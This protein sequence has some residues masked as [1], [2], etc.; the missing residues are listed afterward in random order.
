MGGK[1]TAFIQILNV[2]PVALDGFDPLFALLCEC[3]G[4][5]GS[6][7]RPTDI[8]S[9][10][11]VSENQRRFDVMSHTRAL[12]GVESDQNHFEPRARLNC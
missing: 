4:F 12:R 7:L 11:R 10:E 9:E 8:L 6:L 5:I 3:V 2:L 1:N